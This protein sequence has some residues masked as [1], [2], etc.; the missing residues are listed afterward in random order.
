MPLDPNP[1]ARHPAQH[2]PSVP[3]ARVREPEPQR[4]RGRGRAAPGSAADAEV[5][6]G[7]ARPF[8]ISIDPGRTR[9]VT[10]DPGVDARRA[11][12][13]PAAGAPAP[14]P[15]REVGLDA[16]GRPSSASPFGSAS[17]RTTLGGHGVEQR[18]SSR[19][20][21]RTARS[22][23]AASSSGQ[24][25]RDER[26]RI[27]PPGLARSAIARSPPRVHGTRC[28]ANRTSSARAHHT[29][30]CAWH[31][32]AR[33]HP[34]DARPGRRVARRRARSRTPHA[35]PTASITTSAPRPPVRSNTA[36][37]GLRVADV[38]RRSRPRASA[39]AS[40]SGSRSSAMTSRGAVRAGGL[41]GE[42]P[43][44]ARADDRD[45]V[46]PAGSRPSRRRRRPVGQDVAEE[47][48]AVVLEAVGR[49]RGG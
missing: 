19:A 43:D 7:F 36:V 46:A 14:G 9:T 1:P 10:P 44:G 31:D 33:V 38:D 29:P 16:A 21:R 6:P 27:E 2:R 28:P 13:S 4:G 18:P 48:R 41:R 8:A 42:E 32:L 39:S 5:G 25:V 17:A 11:R 37:C 34:H 40:R 26:Q 45:G 23:V 15:A 47:D 24:P 12:P 30:S 35:M 49:P 20:A 3:A 22:P